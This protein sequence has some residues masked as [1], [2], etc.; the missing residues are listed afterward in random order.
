MQAC[1]KS[2]TMRPRLGTN[3]SILT[4]AIVNMILDA[5]VGSVSAYLS[6]K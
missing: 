6:H 4:P 2:M 1:S 5:L 3:W